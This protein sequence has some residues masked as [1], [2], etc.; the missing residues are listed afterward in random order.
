VSRHLLASAAVTAAALAMAA[1]AGAATFGSP[2]L[3][4]PFFPLAGNGG[5]DVDHYS[6]A[7]DYARA[8]N[9]LEGRATISATAT[10]ALD[11][12]DLDLRGFAVAGVDVN[13]AP[14]AFARDAQELQITPRG[15]LAAGKAF[16]VRVDYAGVPDVITDP[17]G[18]IEGWVPT[19]DG[20]FVVGEPQGSPGWYPANDNPRDKATYDFAIT[21]PAGITALANGVLAGPA[22]PAGGKTTWRWREDDP[23]APY[24][25]TATNGRFDL[26]VQTGPDHLPIYNA[27]DSGLNPKRKATA[28]SLL[29]MAPEIVA[30]FS[31]LYGPYPFNAAGGIVD[32]APDV[33]YSL[34]TQ[35]KPNYAYVPDELTV[36]HELSHM[37]YGDAVTL[38]E[39]PDIW[40]HE[41]FATFSE[42]IW[43]ERHGGESAQATFD[44]LYADRQFPWSP[45]PAA[46]QRPSQLFSTPVYDRGGMT[47]QALRAKVGD[48]TFFRILRDWFVQNRN[49]NVTTPEFIVLAEAESGLDLDAFFDAWIYTPAKPASW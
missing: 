20:A 23:M 18:S 7:L 47:L 19:N 17:D 6:L 31:E 37:W 11:R 24:L 38:T 34:E 12:F 35:T 28:K 13:G 1:P 46:L 22:V 25:A 33:G 45:A 32:P 29:S 5:Y 48:D 44:R 30:F 9:R 49:G 26:D 14:A 39:W 43:R 40:L 3:G 21:V 27:V 16:T 42:W 8:G 4:D 15:R 41:G 36:V 2:G 10:Q